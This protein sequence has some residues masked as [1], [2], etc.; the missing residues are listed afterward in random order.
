MLDE[1]RQIALVR[2]D[3]VRGDVAVQPQELE[4]VLDVC[5]HRPPRIHCSRSSNARV[6]NASLRSNLP[7]GARSSGGM[8]PNVMFDGS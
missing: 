6:D 4:K 7:R 1:L 5:V 2:A 3:G 8:I